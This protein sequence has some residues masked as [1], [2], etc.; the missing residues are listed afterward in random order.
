MKSVSP[1]LNSLNQK[2]VHQMAFESLAKHLN[3]NSKG[4]QSSPPMVWD[5][6]LAAAAN[7]SS[8]D[9]EC[10]QHAGRRVLTP[11]EVW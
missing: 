10:S 3:L 8:I 6:L 4:S 9:D 11:F 2:Q 1:K 5:I 7:K